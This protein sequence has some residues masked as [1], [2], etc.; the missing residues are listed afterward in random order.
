M[1]RGKCLFMVLSVIWIFL[2]GGVSFTTAA[3]YHK[4]FRGR[5]ACGERPSTPLDW[6]REDFDAEPYHITSGYEDVA[7]K[8]RVDKVDLVGWYIPVEDE[9][10]APTVIVVHGSGGGGCRHVPISRCWRAEKRAQLSLCPSH[11]WNH[12]KN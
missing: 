12:S 5:P 8:S 10:P 1:R 3:V 6:S 11:G 9:I 2:L 4:A 7:F